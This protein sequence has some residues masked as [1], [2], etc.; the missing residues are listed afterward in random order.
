MLVVEQKISAI[1]I[2]LPSSQLSVTVSEVRTL[3]PAV[4]K[5]LSTEQVDYYVSV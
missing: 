2:K 3:S 1:I 5:E 4:D